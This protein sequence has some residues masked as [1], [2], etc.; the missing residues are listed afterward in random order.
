MRG[1]GL[2]SNLLDAYLL[3]ARLS[4]RRRPLGARRFVDRSPS[5]PA[6]RWFWDCLASVPALEAHHRPRNPPLGSPRPLGSVT[7]SP[8]PPS[9][10]FPRPPRHSHP[11][12]PSPPPRVPPP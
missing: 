2:G 11:P 4:A 9:T 8:R 3:A 5:A 1:M 6:S 10:P 7:A 12:G